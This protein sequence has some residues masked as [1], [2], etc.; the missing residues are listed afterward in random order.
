VETLIPVEPLRQQRLG[1]E[2]GEQA[3]PPQV[4][5]VGV[6]TGQRAEGHILVDNQG[7]GAVPV[8]RGGSRPAGA[9][10]FDDG[11]G[12]VREAGADEDRDVVGRSVLHRPEVNHPAAAGGQVPQLVEAEGLEPTSGRHLLGIGSHHPGDVLEDLAAAGAEGGGEGHGGGVAAAAAEGGDLLLEANALKTSHDDHESVG[13]GPPHAVALH[14]DDAGV[15]MAVV[16]DDATLGP[17]EGDGAAALG[18]QGHRQQRHG[19]ALT[20]REQHVQ[21]PPGWLPVGLVGELG[22]LIGGLTHGADDDHHRVAGGP[23]GADVP[24]HDAN[25]VDRGERRAAVLA[26]QHRRRDRGGWH[27]HELILG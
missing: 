4:G 12:P 17:G 22:Q 5:G 18:G 9:A 20:D 15:G 7:Q 19:D 25:A 11:A 26:D 27:G 10:G 8:G 2:I 6:G 13:E 3:I 21:L 23:L 14:L 24:G 16:G 1:G